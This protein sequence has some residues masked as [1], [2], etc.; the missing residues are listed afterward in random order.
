MEPE[1]ERV[2]RGTI[3]RLTGM[4]TQSVRDKFPASITWGELVRQVWSMAQDVQESPTTMDL[5]EAELR[6]KS[7]KASLA[8]LEL[9]RAKGE[10]V[11]A[12]Q[13]NEAEAQRLGLLRSSLLVMPDVLRTKAG[14][15]TEQVEILDGYVR[16]SLQNLSDAMMGAADGD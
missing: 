2:P 13:R 4:S 9:A 11:D 15:T 14:L 8:E 7:A 10:L 6:L 5:E 1:H 12:G 3:A 16:V